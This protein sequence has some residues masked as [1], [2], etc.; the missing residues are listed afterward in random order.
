MKD[1]RG[2]RAL[3]TGA[4]RGIGIHIAKALAQ[5]GVS[6]VLTAR[7]EQQLK[8]V[9]Q[10]LESYQVPVEFYVSDM[11][12]LESLSRLFKSATQNGQ[13]IDLLVNNA[14]IYH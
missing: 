7:N 6:L 8:E 3:L 9:A 14:G 12:D 4:S 5:A 10:T 13:V 11:T 2:K 1:I